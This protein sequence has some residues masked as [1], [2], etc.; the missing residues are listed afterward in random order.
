MYPS[1]GP[2]QHGQIQT[3]TWLPEPWPSLAAPGLAEPVSFLLSSLALC[4]GLWP[5]TALPPR[6][7][8]SLQWTFVLALRSAWN[9]L[10]RFLTRPTLASGSGSRLRAHTFSF[11]AARVALSHAFVSVPLQ[12]PSP[13]GVL[14][15]WSVVYLLEV[16]RPAVLVH[17]EQGLPRCQSQRPE[18]DGERNGGFRLHEYVFTAT[19]MFMT[20]LDSAALGSSCIGR[21]TQGETKKRGHSRSFPWAPPT[22]RRWVGVGEI[23]GR[24]ASR[25]SACHTSKSLGTGVEHR[26]LI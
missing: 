5:S 19:E 23:L 18:G 9:V 3:P 11:T 12:P 1:D 15:G 6:Q 13:P 7:A 17:T 26:S 24:R 8:L 14:T 21:R 2:T 16:L 10:C 25:S 20:L 4:S 22:R